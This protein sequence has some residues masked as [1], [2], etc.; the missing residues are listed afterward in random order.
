MVDRMGGTPFGPFLHLPNPPS[1]ILTP[2]PASHHRIAQQNPSH[3]MRNMSNFVTAPFVWAHR[4]QGKLYRR[5]RSNRLLLGERS[6][7]FRVHVYICDNTL[8]VPQQRMNSNC[9]IDLHWSEGGTSEQLWTDM[10]NTKT[11]GRSSLPFS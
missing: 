10:R 3:T 8:R 11:E 5:E 4:P 6:V 9:E 7:R 2:A 1:N